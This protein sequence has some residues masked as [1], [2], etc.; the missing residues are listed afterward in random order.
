L[1]VVPD[2]WS[3]A[4]A[5]GPWRA[6]ERMR[7]LSAFASGHHAEIRVK[8]RRFVYKRAAIV[9]PKIWRTWAAAVTGPR[10]RGSAPWGAF[11][12]RRW[13]SGWDIC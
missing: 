7:R 9:G 4:G 12:S 11:L 13:L 2:T 3:H 10:S 8:R 1:R 5:F 6:S